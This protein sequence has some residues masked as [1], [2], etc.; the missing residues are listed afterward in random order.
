MF[1]K[2]LIKLKF[3]KIFKLCEK[4][5]FKGDII[6]CSKSRDHETGQLTIQVPKFD[7][8]KTVLIIDD[9]CLAGNTFINIRKEIPNKNVVLA[10]SHGIFND[11]IDK[12]EESF[13]K[14]YSTNSRSDKP[15]GDKFKI[16][17]Y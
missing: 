11:N 14:I 9:I 12:L 2:K 15:K 17:Y 13:I 4:L 16:L 7:E 3:K 5:D 8:N 1:L 6:T 10:V